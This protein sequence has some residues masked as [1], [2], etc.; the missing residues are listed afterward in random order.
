VV[1]LL[2]E[3]RSARNRSGTAAAKKT[4]FRDAAAFDAHREL[5]DVAANGIADFYLGIR[6]RK[7][8]GVARILKVIENGVA[9]HP[10]EYSNAAFTFSEADIFLSVAATTIPAA[11]REAA[12]LEGA[13][14]LQRQDTLLQWKG[15]V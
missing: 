11:K 14:H 2:R 4:R 13:H 10:Q 3:E 9:K 1:Q 7:L 5:Q 8:A 15:P 6:A 12:A